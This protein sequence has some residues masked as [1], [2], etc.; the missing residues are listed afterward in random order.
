[1]VAWTG[2]CLLVLVAPFE[3]L[4][5]IVRLPGQSLT[6][7]ELALLAVLSAWLAA[8][9]LFRQRPPSDTTHFAVGD[10]AAHDAIAAAV[11]P[12]DRTNAVHM[13]ARFGLAFGAF[14]VTVSG[15]ST[16]D[17]LRRVVVSGRLSA[18]PSALVMLGFWER[19]CFGLADL[20]A[21]HRGRRI[22][23]PCPRAVLYRRLPRCFEIVFAFTLG[24]LPEVVVE[25]RWWVVVAVIAARNDRGRRRAHVYSSRSSDAPVLPAGVIR[26][27]ARWASMPRYAVALVGLVVAVEIVTSRSGDVLGLRMTTESQ[28]NWY[29]AEINAPL[30]VALKTGTVSSVPI[31]VTNSGS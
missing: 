18:W 4:H 21:W 14:L 9:L 17:R 23:G 22:A 1:M 7:V 13:V 19:F 6:I 11:A 31:N 24:L 25:K 3:A 27:P 29:L 12:V 5:P 30:T 26:L 2:V 20:Q 28:D 16:P 10:G 8:A 15:I